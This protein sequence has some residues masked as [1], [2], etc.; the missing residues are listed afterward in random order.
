MDEY[1]VDAFR[2]K[3][4]FVRKQNTGGAIYLESK[5]VKRTMKVAVSILGADPPKTVEQHCRGVL[6]AGAD[7]IHIDVMDG[8]CVPNT[9]YAGNEV[10]EL[11][12]KLPDAYFD[13]H[14][15]VVDPANWVE[16]MAQAKVNVFTYHYEEVYNHEDLIKKIRDHGMRVGVALRS[17]TP[18]DVLDD[19]IDLIDMVLIVTVE[20]TGVGGQ[21]LMPS[22]I[23]KSKKLKEKWP[24]VEIE[25][26][27]GLNLSTT[28]LAKSSGA[29]IVVGG[30]VILKAEDIE[31][32]I[33]QMR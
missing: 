1:I 2:R 22:M 3:F 26:D 13:C 32:V 8:R 24:R 18:I 7:W 33:K 29:D 30:W 28:E 17:T 9:K 6:D 12:Q 23:E 31:G 11:R 15:M 10:L 4:W 20:H 5:L 27:G 19:I 25:I 14:M 21:A 16:K